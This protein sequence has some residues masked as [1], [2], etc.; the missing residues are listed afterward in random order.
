MYLT[1]PPPPSSSPLPFH[2]LPFRNLYPL[3]PVFPHPTVSFNM[4]TDTD[5][6]ITLK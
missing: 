4:Q 6:E 1:I 2:P 3:S 5:T